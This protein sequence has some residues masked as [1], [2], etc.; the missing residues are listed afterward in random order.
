MLWLGSRWILSC[1]ETGLYIWIDY[2]WLEHP[3]VWNI[4]TVSSP[5]EISIIRKHR[6]TN[7][8]YDPDRS[9]VKVVEDLADPSLSVQ[10][11]KP[12]ADAERKA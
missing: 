6:L 4:F 9:R 3:F 12:N 5:T 1:C 8:F 11:F 2:P 10:A 7:L